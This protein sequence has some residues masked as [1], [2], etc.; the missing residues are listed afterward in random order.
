MHPSVYERTTLNMTLSRRYNDKLIK[1][2][3]RG[4]PLPDTLAQHE[5]K[6]S[7]YHYGTRVSR[8]YARFGSIIS[9]KQSMDIWINTVEVLFEIFL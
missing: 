3:K 9:W 4:P 2:L 6:S 7:N 5:D 8:A 1:T